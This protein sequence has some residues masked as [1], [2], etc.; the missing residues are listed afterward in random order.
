M[1]RPAGFS[2]VEVMLATALLAAGI[3]LAFATLGNATVAT[4]RAEAAAQRQERL[5]AV[6][7][8]L[9]GQVEGALPLP[10][11]PLDATGDLIVFEADAD[12]LRLVAAM[13]GYL[14]RGGPHLQTFRLVRGAGG[15]R[16]EFV[17]QL[18]TPE[19]PLPPE[20]EPEILLDGITQGRFEVRT[21]DEGGK[22]GAWTTRWDQ[23]SQIP[24]LVRLQLDLADPRAQWPGLVAAPRLAQMP[25]AMPPGQGSGSLRVGEP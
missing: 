14:S 12:T 19:G 6:Q 1:T 10:F 9:R 7:G 25:V 23:P 15:T 21:L 2:L 20:R 13:P 24:R 4:E 16:L 8:F 17:H 5:R 22:P 3:V 18:L 11:E